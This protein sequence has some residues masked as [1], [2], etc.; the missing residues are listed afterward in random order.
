V[1]QLSQGQIV[2]RLSTHYAHT[3]DTTGGNSG[4][5]ILH[6]DQIIGVVTHCPCP[7]FAQRIDRPSFASAIEALCP[8]TPVPS[9][10]ICTNPLVVG[11]GTTPFSTVGAFTTGPSEDAQCTIFGDGQIHN[12]IWYVHTAQCDGDLTISLCGSSYQT[13]LAV[14]NLPCPTNPG[15]VLACDLNSC[16]GESRAQVTIPATFGQSFRIRIGGHA[17]ATGEGLLTI[18]C[19]EPTEPCPADLTGSCTVG[20]ADLLMLIANWTG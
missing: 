1:Q 17:G 12:D 2:Q 16:V 7:N 18:S 19:T 20:V 8:S 14:Y 11:G 9:N 10:N 5:A 15:T 13:K 6:N 3:A 4:S